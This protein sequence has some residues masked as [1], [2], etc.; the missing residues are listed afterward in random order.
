MLDTVK[1]VWRRLVT[2]LVA[3]TL[4][5]LPLVVTV[6]V[7]VWTTDLALRYLGP[8]TFIGQQLERIGVQLRPDATTP[9]LIG[10]GTILLFILGIGALAEFGIQRMFHRS[11]D[12]LIGRIPI[13]G[14]VYSTSRQLIEMLESKDNNA[15][16]GM[17]GVFCRLGSTRVLALLVSPKQF[18]LS[19]V[20]C[21][22]VIIPTAPVPFGGALVFVPVTD[23]ENANLSPEGLMSIFVS[24]GVSA[25]NYLPMTSRSNAM[26]GT[27]PPVSNS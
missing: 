19:D 1:F 3:G 9:Y 15:V 6:A 24:L 22:C 20:D 26:P 21:Y 23:V 12:W 18:H 8:R 5:I 27:T 14:S 17:T 10:W 13:V 16:S 2:C 11:A 4:T 25:E 7:V